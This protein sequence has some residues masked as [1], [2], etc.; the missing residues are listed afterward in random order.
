MPTPM[1]FASERPLN[2]GVLD[3]SPIPGGLTGGDALRNT[4]VLANP[5]VADKLR[6]VILQ[7]TP[8]G[9]CDFSAAC[10]SLD[11]IPKPGGATG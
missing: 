5:K 7:S 1:T 4:V 11:I 8:M 2:L 3:Q 6:I 9:A 10:D